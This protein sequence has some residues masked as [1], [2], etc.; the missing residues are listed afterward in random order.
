VLRKI[1]PPSTP[2]SGYINVRINS[3]SINHGDKTFLRLPASA[4]LTTGAQLEDVWGA[5]GAGTV[6]EIGPDV[7]SR[8]LG[9]KV[10]L[11]RGLRPADDA[12]GLWSEI[13]QVPYQTALLLPDHVDEKDYS[14]S[15]VNA[16]T[17]Y[18]FLEQAVVEGHRGII[19]T[20]GSSA[21]G[22][23]LMVL[24][25]QRCIPVL[26][27]VRGKT[28]K[29]ELKSEVEVEHILS[30]DDPDFLPELEQKAKE[31]GT[32]AVFDG[33]GGSLISKMLPVLPSGS[34]IF[35]YGFLSGAEKVEFPS[36]VFMRRNLSMK[37]FSNFDTV[38]VK[39]NLGDM[40]IYLEG[41]IEDPAFRTSL[42]KQFKPEEIEAAFEYEGGRKKAVLVFSV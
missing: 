6:T 26:V 40:L 9:R 29:E 24:A 23:A 12:L 3:A 35:F 7:P 39:E 42:G 33:V 34:S 2:P 11:Y 21:T 36:A 4:R 27:I 17:A 38:T 22:R 19:V 32:T 18:A 16:G 20:A 41:C 5:S 37:R 8:Y 1:T 10:T 31:L 15:L 13:V 30:S 25:R 14:G 28:S